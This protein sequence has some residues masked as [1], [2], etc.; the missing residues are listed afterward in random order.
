MRQIRIAASLALIATLVSFVSS[1]AQELPVK[2]GEKIAFLGDP[3][4]AAGS[5]SASGYVWLVIHGLEA[6]GIKTTPIHA[7]VSGNTSS[8]MLSRLD[9]DVIS[10]KPDWMTLSCG[11]NDVWHGVNGVALDQYKKN[12]TEIVDKCQAAGIKVMILTSTMIGED[13]PNDNNQKLVAYNAFLR[14]LAKDK[15]CLLADLNADMQAALKLP[16]GAPTRKGNV[17]TVDGVHMNP[18]GNQVMAAGIL[19]GFGISAAQLQKARDTWLDIPNAV[20]VIGKTNVTLRQYDQLSRLAE[21][22]H[23]SVSDLV[24][25]Q[26]NQ[27]IES[28]AK[29]APADAA[30]GK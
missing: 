18:L 26:V 12:I 4:T 14:D 2:S 28:L 20:E 23:R 3:I 30:P 15:K 5:N 8:D 13:Q 1:V 7:G 6:N 24:N 11:V 29:S 27:A 9:R 16:E 21:S 10:K 17:L 25:D 22:Q 19:K